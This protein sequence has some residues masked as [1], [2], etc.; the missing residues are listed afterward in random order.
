MRVSIELSKLLL[1]SSFAT[2]LQ[3]VTTRRAT[4]AAERVE[5]RLL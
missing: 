1:R 4:E 2:L 5:K 3:D